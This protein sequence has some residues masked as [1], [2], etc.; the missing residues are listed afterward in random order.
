MAALEEQPQALHHLD[1]L[2]DLLA[3]LLVAQ[4]DLPARQEMRP[5]RLPRIQ[6][7]W[8]LLAMLRALPVCQHLRPQSLLHPDQWHRR[9]ERLL[10]A[11]LK[12]HQPH[13]AREILVIRIHRSMKGAR[14]LK[15]VLEFPLRRADCVSYQ[16]QC[17]VLATMCWPKR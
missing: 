3:D 5:E 11:I 16:S 7:R 13:S 4:A 17:F 9:K 14:I 15:G 10:A 8:A 2:V 12:E 1:H 6:I